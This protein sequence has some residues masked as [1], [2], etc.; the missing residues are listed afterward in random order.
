MLGRNHHDNNSRLYVDKDFSNGSQAHAHTPHRPQRAKRAIPDP[1]GLSNLGTSVS[2]LSLFEDHSS[3]SSIAHS[4]LPS[5][6][7]TISLANSLVDVRQLDSGIDIQEPPRPPHKRSN[8]DNRVIQADN[9]YLQDSKRNNQSRQRSVQKEVSPVVAQKQMAKESK[10]PKLIVDEEEGDDNYFADILDKYC[11][12]D[13]ELTLPISSS[14]YASG[15]KGLQSAQPPP[16]VSRSYGRDTNS[17]RRAA[18]TVVAATIS[19]REN[20]YSSLSDIPSHETTRNHQGRNQNNSA[21]DLSSPL[22]TATAKF[23]MYNQSPA[24]RNSRESL[25]K[26]T[27]SSPH[28]SSGPFSSITTS[29]A[30]ATTATPTGRSYSKRP[31]PP[32]KD[33]SGSSFSLPPSKPSASSSASRATKPPAPSA[34]Y[35]QSTRT[36]DRSYHDDSS[37]DPR[38]SKPEPPPKDSARRGS[39]NHSTSSSNHSGSQPP[40]L[41]LDTQSSEHF[42]SFSEVVEASMGRRNAAASASASSSTPGQ[43]YDTEPKNQAHSNSQSSSRTRSNSG[44]SHSSNTP[45]QTMSRSSDQ[46][47]YQSS[48]FGAR[49]DEFGKSQNHV[50]EQDPRNQRGY[51]DQVYGGQHQTS[52]HSQQHQQYP[53][54]NN[55]RSTHGS[56]SQ[57]DLSWSSHKSNNTPSTSSRAS[58]QPAP[59]QNE[60]V[61]SHSY[62][63]IQTNSS[64]SL[65]GYPGSS[66]SVK[67][68]LVKTPIARARAKEMR[69]SRKVNFG[70]IITVVTIERAETPPPVP[71]MDKKARKKLLQAKKNASSKN[72]QMQNF[73]PEY[74]AAFFNAPYTPTP[75]EVIVTQAPWIG[76]PNYDEEKAN[77][78]FYNEDEFD[79]EYDE[80]EYDTQYEPDIRLGPED[81]DEDDDEDEE[82]DEDEEY[83]SR[84][85][86][87][88]IAGPGGALPKKKGGMFKRAVNRLLRN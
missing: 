20:Q 73:D 32:P 76:N 4:S 69:G 65:S 39:H 63:S 1:T 47:S 81:D 50:Y 29:A 38:E 77:S 74:N 60:R 61:R 15:R 86:G 46:S 27:S 11:N 28:L 51:E 87:H 34:P 53:A 78:K 30:A 68:A 24:I 55:Q 19:S 3:M 43:Y 66:R 88:G 14:S 22:N 82:E 26:S 49:L 25:S 79:S 64:V 84:K 83:E 9:E 42:N 18:E 71:P 54:H 6:P 21:S 36:Y 12:S 44:Q 70:D 52:Q 5:T 13:D 33:D 59:Y 37:I 45:H 7:S 85:W 67:P 48:K 35:H 80:D 57:L 23:N 56:T 2:Q 16:P 40:M 62:G 41:S 17:S 72:G 58:N 10:S 8:R 31:H 75:A